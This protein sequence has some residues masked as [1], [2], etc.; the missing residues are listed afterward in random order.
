MAEEVTMAGCAFRWVAAIG[1]VSVVVTGCGRK[2][3]SPDE[4]S[5]PPP[6][7]VSVPPQAD[8]ETA[9]VNR[10]PNLHQ[11]FAQATTAM[12]PD[13]VDRPPDV[14]MTGKSVGKFYKDVVKRWQDI[15]FVSTA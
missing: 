3:P 9:P 5:D 6:V 13:G 10:D 1:I 14:T 2:E 15:S 8:R 11:T 7:S 4:P 12:P